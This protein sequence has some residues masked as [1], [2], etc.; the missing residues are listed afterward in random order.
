[1]RL[2]KLGALGSVRISPLGLQPT[3]EQVS[4]A[5]CRNRWELTL[6]VKVKSKQVV[7][8]EIPLDEQRYT[9]E[10]QTPTMHMLNQI[11]L[12]RRWCDTYKSFWMWFYNENNHFED[13]FK[14]LAEEQTAVLT[15]F[16]GQ[17][18]SC[19]HTKRSVPSSVNHL[20]AE[21]DSGIYSLCVLHPHN[22][23]AVT[24]W[25]VGF[26]LWAEKTAP[27]HGQNCFPAAPLA[28]DPPLRGSCPTPLIFLFSEFD[29]TLHSPSLW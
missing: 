7:C 1:M 24:D 17:L 27:C 19:F 15:M 4:G 25:Q 12:K 20:H 3:V 22:A 28:T 2:I 6:Q 16:P 14:V 9:T 11:K 26:T 21:R 13:E 5:V 29:A 8:R 10:K 23:L 18:C